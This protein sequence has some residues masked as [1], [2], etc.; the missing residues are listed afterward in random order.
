MSDFIQTLFIVI[1]GIATGTYALIYWWDYQRR[2][3]RRSVS[4]VQVLNR[5]EGGYESYRTIGTQPQ[6]IMCEKVELL[7]DGSV[8]ITFG[9]SNVIAYARY[10][11][12]RT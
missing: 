12:W 10:V 11:Q 6:A 8:E 9:N 5:H 7:S 4:Y 3:A 1:T 2:H